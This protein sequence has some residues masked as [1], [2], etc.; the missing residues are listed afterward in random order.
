MTKFDKWYDNQTPATKA[1]LDKQAIW[2]GKDLAFVS[3]IA[4]V[5]GVFFGLCF[6]TGF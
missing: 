2:H 3:A 6:G 4:F 1:W 5:V